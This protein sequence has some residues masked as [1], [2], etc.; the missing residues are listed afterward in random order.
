MGVIKL[1]FKKVLSLL[2]TAAML[3]GMASFAA[4]AASA[5]SSTAAGNYY[6]A[7]YLESYANSAY[8]ESGLGSVYSKD[9]TTWKTWSPEAT[10][11]KLKLYNKD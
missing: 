6:N 7:D 1:K 11:V 4:Q 9:S 3:S 5:P 8:N 10:S 2:L